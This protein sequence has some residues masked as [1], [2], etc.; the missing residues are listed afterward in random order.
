MTRTSAVAVLL[1]ILLLVTFPSASASAATPVK[2][3]QLVYAITPWT[4][5]DYGETFAARD[6]DTI[7][8]L[9]D[10]ANV[11][12]PLKTEVYFWEITG[13]YKADIQSYMEEVSG[14]LEVLQSGQT[15]GILTKVKHSYVYSEGLLGGNVT[16]VTGAEA[17]AE[18]ERYKSAVDRYQKEVLEYQT[19][20]AEFNARI[21]ELLRRARETGEPVKPEDIPEPPSTPLP[22]AFFVTAPIESFVLELPEGSY[23][24]RV[25]DE[26]GRIV[27][28]RVKKL[29]VFGPRRRGISY[30]IIPESKWTLP[31]VSN[32]TSQAMFVQGQTTVYLKLFEAE[33]YN[34]YEYTKMIQLHKPSAGQGTE[35]TWTWVHL[36]ELTDVKVQILQGDSM[37]GEV[38]EKPY[39]V[40]QAPGYALGYDI[41]EYDPGDPGMQ[42]SR[43]HFTAFKLDLD[44]SESYRIQA[45]VSSS[46][47]LIPESVREILPLRSTSSL[48]LVVAA[49]IP[50]AAG[51]AVLAC[52]RGSRFHQTGQ[53]H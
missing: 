46:G 13:E 10:A 39:F 49:F 34:T 44:N 40:K 2:E 32:D 21:S 47:A 48:W 37:L 24:I 5:T 35:N 16:L 3:R 9:A 23:D 45:V 18:F 30:E 7:Y 17:E 20:E 14:D 27:P 26:L 36:K 29:V 51:V 53:F 11:L 8:L 42:D 33:E 19:A 38:E 15:I 6:T 28:E 43:P 4:G 52:R 22:P 1:T 25:R 31:V 12:R 41:V 50:L